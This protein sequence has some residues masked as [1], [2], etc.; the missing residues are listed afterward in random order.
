MYNRLVRLDIPRHPPRLELY[1]T[2]SGPISTRL[3]CEGT[4]TIAIKLYANLNTPHHWMSPQYGKKQQNVTNPDI[5]LSPLP[6]SNYPKVCGTLP[7]LRHRYRQYHD[8]YDWLNCNQRT[9]GNLQIFKLP[10]TS[11]TIPQR[12]PMQKDDSPQSIC[13]FGVTHLH[14]I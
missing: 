10:D 13:N 6:D 3:H 12:I 7:I 9:H 4:H 11:S 1:P 14:L 5:P 8:D 2:N